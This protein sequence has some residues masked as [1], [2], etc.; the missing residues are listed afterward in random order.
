MSTNRSNWPSTGGVYIIRFSDTHYYVGRAS[1]FKVRWSKHLLDLTRGTHANPHMAA[2]YAIH[3]RFE[4]EV[5]SVIDPKGP[6]SLREAEQA[7]LDLHVGRDGCLNI[8][9][10]SEDIMSGRKH[11]DA[12]KIK[13]KSRRFSE[14]TKKLWSENRKGHPVSEETRRKLSEVLKGKARPDTSLR[15]KEN[16]GWK[17]TDDAREK[18]S[19]AGRRPC[20]DTTKQKIRE[21]HQAKGIRPPPG[22]MRGHKHSEEAKQKISLGQKKREDMTP[23]E[24]LRRS[25]QTKRGWATRRSR[26]VG[27]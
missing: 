3:H 23:E 25:E 19:A 2:V 14:E 17:H 7:L 13:F 12:T 5:V 20:A 8:C 16:V 6:V 15:N 10:V 18:I 9:K 1:N 22:G 27:V 4:P 11:S 24:R 21:N 26:K